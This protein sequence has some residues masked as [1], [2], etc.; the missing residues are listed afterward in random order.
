MKKEYYRG[1]EHLLE[2]LKNLGLSEKE[3]KIYLALLQLGPSTPYQIA[4]K[5]EI[6]RPT[7][8]VIAEELVE[9]G[10]IVHVPGED[11]KR[12]IART[13]DAF[14]EEQ[15]EKLRAARAIL[16]ELRSFQKGT[17]EKPSIMYYEGAEGVRQAYEYKKRE[18]HGKEIVGFFASPE[19]A[20]PEVTKV[21]ME[22]NEYKEKYGPKVRGITVDNS[23]LKDYAK[24]LEPGKGSIEAKFMPPELYSAKVSIESCDKQFVRICLIESTQTLII[25]S[26]KF[27]IAIGEAF[28]L[29]W[30]ALEGKYDRPRALTFD[31]E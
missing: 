3:A 1:M 19:D 23:N 29:L 16:P 24:Y 12:Y 5:A 9:K 20:S 8:Y 17:V 11:K 25:E 13:P 30:K 6:K 2:P 18:L 7:A 14:I 27:A 22:W 31:P 15:G 28:E 4:N 10:L 26:P 21:F